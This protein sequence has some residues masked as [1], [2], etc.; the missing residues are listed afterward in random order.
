[1]SKSLN[2][3]FKECASE[4]RAA[5]IGY[6]TAGFPNLEKSK[7]VAKAMIEGGVDIIEVGFPYSDPVMDGPVIQEASQIALENKTGAVEVLELTKSIAELGTPVLVMSYWNPIE[8]YGTKKFASDLASIG[9]SG[10]ITPDLTIEEA[11]PWLAESQTNNLVNVFV[12]APSTK[13]NR[14]AAVTGKG[15]GFVYAA[16]LMGVTGTRNSIS[17]DAKNLVERV[18]KHSELPV[19]VGLGVSN[20]DQA[21]EVASYADGVI[22]GSAFIKRVIEASSFE[23]ALVEVKQLA[24]ALREAMAK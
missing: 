18:R 3:V 15:S 14:I 19:C 8:K 12:V 11:E 22:V 1:M 6:V 10:T 9:S 4:N 16:S 7:T 13:D 5:L 23:G 24:S 2:S 21:Q 17:T 20:P